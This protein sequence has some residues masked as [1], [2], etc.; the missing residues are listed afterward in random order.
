MPGISLK[1]KID[2]FF[3]AGLKKS[4]TFPRASCQ[5]R[6]GFWFGLEVISE[7]SYLYPGAGSSFQGPAL[8]SGAG[9]PGWN[10]YPVGTQD[11]PLVLPPR[12]Y[13]KV[14]QVRQHQP[15]LWEKE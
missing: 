2:F 9:C 13:L 4:N 11:I 5:T 3:S 6:R 8:S 1:K 10:Q 12:N 15:P 7:L 14:Q